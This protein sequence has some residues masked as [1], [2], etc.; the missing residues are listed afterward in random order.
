M[1]SLSRRKV[2][3]EGGRKAGRKAAKDG[4]GFQVDGPRAWVWHLSV[5]G[6]EAR[7]QTGMSAQGSAARAGGDRGGLKTGTSVGS[8]RC[9]S[10]VR[11]TWGSSIVASRRMRAATA[12]AGE[13]VEVEGALHQVGPRP[14]AGFAGSLATELGDLRRGGVGDGVC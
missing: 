5:A 6:A 2:D 7:G 10:I 13:H 11:M 9:A 8:P 1:K 12:R 14:V 3:D 4:P